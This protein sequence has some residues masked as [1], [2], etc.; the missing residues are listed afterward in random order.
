MNQPQ[1]HVPQVQVQQG[2]YGQPQGG[3]WM[4]GR[5]G[6]AHQF[7][8]NTNLC[9]VGARGRSG[10]SLDQ[11]QLLFRDITTGQFV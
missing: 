8:H 2:Q 10:A 7:A 3:Q 5:G 11:L 1:V 9:L 4:G 6:S